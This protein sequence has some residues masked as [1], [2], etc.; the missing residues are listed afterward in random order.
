L[1]ELIPSKEF[2]LL[3]ETKRTSQRNEE[4]DSKRKRIKISEESETSLIPVSE[5]PIVVNSAV[6]LKA[7]EPNTSYVYC[8]GAQHVSNGTPKEGQPEVIALLI[9]SAALNSTE[10]DSLLEVSCRVLNLQMWPMPSNST[11]SN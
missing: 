8:P 4:E 5:K 2:V 10:P 6:T 11:R 7:K 3:K 9:P 1:L